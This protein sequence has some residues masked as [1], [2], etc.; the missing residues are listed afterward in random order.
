MTREEL[1]DSQCMQNMQAEMGLLRKKAE[2]DRAKARAAVAN[3]AQMSD[4]NKRLREAN[5]DAVALLESSCA[6][7]LP[8][9]L[10]TTLLCCMCKV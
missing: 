2:T 3:A 8:P 4:E 7:P 9:R 1:R 5:P 10:A 6:S